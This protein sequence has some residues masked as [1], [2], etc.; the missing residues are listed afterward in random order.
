[1]KVSDAPAI[2]AYRSVPAVCLYQGRHKHLADTLR[3][4]KSVNKN[5]VNTPDTWHQ[6]TLIEKSSGILIGDLGVHFTGK[7]NRQVE[8]AY[9]L[10]PEYQGKGYAAEAVRR[11]LSYVFGSLRKH[12]VVATADPRNKSPVKLMKRVGMRREGFFKKSF[13]T[14]KD[15]SDDVLYAILKEE[16]CEEKKRS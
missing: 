3:M 10:A 5:P 7:E 2:F 4:I 12:R 1:V 11:L 8:I 13:W 14:G 9:T 16:W 15:W 6:F